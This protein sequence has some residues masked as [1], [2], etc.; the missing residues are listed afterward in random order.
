MT[1]PQP[2]V[3]SFIGLLVSE[4][5]WLRSPPIAR[6]TSAWN[7]ASSV[8][9][10]GTNDLDILVACKCPSV[11]ELLAAATLSQWWALPDGSSADICAFTRVTT[12]LHEVL[13]LVWRIILKFALIK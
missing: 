11:W 6:S 5:F 7:P 10:T 9:Y 12:P 1:L 2:S 8:H 4:R 13:H 3:F